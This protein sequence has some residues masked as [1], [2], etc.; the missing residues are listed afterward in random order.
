M[1]RGLLILFAAGFMLFVD[2]SAS[3]KDAKPAETGAA[4]SATAASNVSVVSPVAAQTQRCTGG[5][6]MY[7][8]AEAWSESTAQQLAKDDAVNGCQY[9]GGTASNPVVVA[10]DWIG[11]ERY[12]AWASAKCCCVGLH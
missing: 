2:V 3:A 8:Y 12:P 4:I 6:S 1:K 10:S 5:V 11:G 7:G 9:Q